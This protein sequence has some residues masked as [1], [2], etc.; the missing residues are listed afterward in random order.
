MVVAAFA[1]FFFIISA[2][3]RC[4]NDEGTEWECTITS[5]YFQS[6]AML[7]NAN[8]E[9]LDWK[10][11][12]WQQTAVSFCFAVVVGILLLNIL[13]AKVTN[14]FTEVTD[15]SQTA[16]WT[17]RLD[18]VGEVNAIMRK[19]KPIMN[20]LNKIMS[21]LIPE[22]IWSK[23]EWK[24]PEEKVPRR[25]LGVYEEEW[26]MKCHDKDMKDF[27]MWWYY[28]WKKD[29]KRPP[30]RTRLKYFY[31]YAS[32][33]DIMFPG[34]VFQ[35]IL[36]G[37]KYNEDL[38]GAKMLIAT[39]LSY[40]HFLAGF[41][42]AVVIFVLGLVSFGFLWPKEMNEVLFFGPVNTD[43]HKVDD[44]SEQENQVLK[45]K[46]ERLEKQVSNIERLVEKQVSNLERLE[47]LLL[48]IVKIENN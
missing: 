8:F 7:L 44:K 26:M 18:F 23:L 37:R 22:V 9:F 45:N 34:Q 3:D 10:P 24:Q 28:A 19:L 36:F 32:M 42:C 47:D 43:G 12:N 21:K 2:G 14:V 13:I 31:K 4:N 20:K 33:E 46:V 35:N 15:E 16:F 25:P 39:A 6:F 41:I 48:Q 29:N 17:N 38:K 5:S 27:F 11:D 40:L 30:L 1:Q